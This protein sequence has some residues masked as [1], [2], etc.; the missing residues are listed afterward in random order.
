[1]AQHSKKPLN[2]E[3]QRSPMLSEDFKFISLLVAGTLVLLGAG[4]FLISGVGG[5]LAVAGGI[6]L[7]LAGLAVGLFTLYVV[8]YKHGR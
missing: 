8:N 4:L 1:M 2:N 6:L 7:V 3:A 5:G